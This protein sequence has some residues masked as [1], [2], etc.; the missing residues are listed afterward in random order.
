M[1]AFSVGLV[2]AV[3]MIVCM[4]TMKTENTIW[5]YPF[6][7]LTLPLIYIFFAIYGNDFQALKL[8]TLIGLPFLI[9]AVI[10]FKKDVRNSAYI[11]AL[12]WLLHGVYDALHPT[13]FH[14]AGAPLWWPAFCGSVDIVVGI[15]LILL[16]RSLP[17]SSLVRTVA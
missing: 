15:Y 7:L 6:T 9:V 3:F 4:R 17:K 1:I 8:E 11:M 14:N 12:A 13:L 10:C 5:A 16:A 2:M